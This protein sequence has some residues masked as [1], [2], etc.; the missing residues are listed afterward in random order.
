MSRPGSAT[1][2]ACSTTPRRAPRRFS[3]PPADVLNAEE[4]IDLGAPTR[5]A[6]QIRGD[7]A[8]V[9]AAA[10]LLARAERP[11]IMAGDAVAQSRA[12]AEL[13]ELAELVGAPVYP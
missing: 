10:T 3:S 1:P 13:V 12:H 7:R 2:W 6:P 5:V 11:L 8:A 4:E 9:E